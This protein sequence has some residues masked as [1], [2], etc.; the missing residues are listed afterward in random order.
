MEGIDLTDLARR[1]NNFSG[2]DLKNLAVCAALASL[3]DVIPDMW[4]AK[5]TLK[6]GKDKASDE[7]EAKADENK[8]EE[9]K[10]PEDAADENEEEDEDSDDEE[11]T[12]DVAPRILRPIHFKAAFEQVSATCSR[13]MASVQKLRNWAAQF[14]RDSGAGLGTT[15]TPAASL[16]NGHAHPGAAP[17]TTASATGGAAGSTTTTG[18]GSTYRG[19][20]T[21]DGLWD[22]RYE[23]N[24]LSRFSNLP[25]PGGGGSGAGG[26]GAGGSGAS[27]SGGTTGRGSGGS[28]SGSG[29]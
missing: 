20:T 13:D 3:K 26:S 16:A 23:T 2:S 29:L 17:T 1:T 15:P 14:S 28:G 24:M 8:E 5:K 12:P 10:E 9:K 27:G 22:H 21:G 7:D 25:R 4:N 19:L 6:K 11:D 18:T